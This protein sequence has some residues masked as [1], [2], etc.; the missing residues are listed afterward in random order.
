MLSPKNPYH[1]CNWQ[2]H[3]L[4]FFTF[5]LMPKQ[6]N[7]KTSCGWEGASW[8]QTVCGLE[9]TGMNVDMAQVAMGLIQSSTITPCNY[10]VL[11]VSS[12]ALISL[13]IKLVV[14]CDM[15]SPLLCDFCFSPV[16]QMTAIS[17]F[18][19]NYSTGAT[20]ENQNCREGCS[21]TSC[22]GQHIKTHSTQKDRKKR[23]PITRSISV[24]A[25]TT[26]W[27]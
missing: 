23:E 8:W 21:P 19:S 26:N 13:R 5:S 24:G 2:G 17:A 10:F 6:K 4:G 1:R 7:G 12:V 16:K 20:G 3:S 11:Y 27:Q 9:R 14:S 25:R 22:I 18:H 15:F